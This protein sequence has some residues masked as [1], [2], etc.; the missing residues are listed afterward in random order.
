[1]ISISDSLRSMIRIKP[2]ILVIKSQV[3]K[4][5][6]ELFLLN[7]AGNIRHANL[8]SNQVIKTNYSRL[9]NLG[10]EV[11]IVNRL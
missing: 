8:Y 1:M 7:N 6:L 10:I 2:S 11:Q 9:S 5:L 3:S 4:D